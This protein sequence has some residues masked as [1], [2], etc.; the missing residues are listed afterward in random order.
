MKTYNVSMTEREEHRKLKD[1]WY[2]AAIKKGFKAEKEFKRMMEVPHKQGYD[3][4][5]GEL[6]WK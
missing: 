1:L 3:I 6:K 2:G 4:E 5:E